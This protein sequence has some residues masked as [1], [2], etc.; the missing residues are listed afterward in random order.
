[1]LDAHQ[2]AAQAIASTPAEH[3]TLPVV[4]AA[5]EAALK[6]AEKYKDLLMR[7]VRNHTI[8]PPSQT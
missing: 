6:D 1:M 4:I 7:A 5:V 8:N 2:Y 3:G